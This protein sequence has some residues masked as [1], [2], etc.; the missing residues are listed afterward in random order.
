VTRTKEDQGWARRYAEDDGGGRRERD[1]ILRTPTIPCL[2]SNIDH[3]INGEVARG[4]R[5]H[6]SI[7]SET[8]RCPSREWNLD[9]S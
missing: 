3:M 5:R 6:Q 9:G 4:S 2:S 1:E 7:G 8:W